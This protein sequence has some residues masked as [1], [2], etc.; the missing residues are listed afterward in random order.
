MSVDAVPV[1]GV[2]SGFPAKLFKFKFGVMPRSMAMSAGLCPGRLGRPARTEAKSGCWLLPDDFWGNPDNA[3]RFA[4]S[5]DWA[6]A[7][8]AGLG[9]FSPGCGDF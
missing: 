6:A 7:V 3:R 5:A 2:L 9:R 8:A 4:R 1:A